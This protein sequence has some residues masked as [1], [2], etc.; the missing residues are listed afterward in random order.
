MSVVEASS[1]S[2]HLDALLG[3]ANETHC[4][5][6]TASRARRILDDYHLH[7]RALLHVAN[8]LAVP[9]NHLADTMRRHR[10]VLGVLASGRARVGA[11]LTGS[12]EID[13]RLLAFPVF[14]CLMKYV[15]RKFEKAHLK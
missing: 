13:N 3:I 12:D 9:S 11:C 15:L 10:H 14:F 6:P 8:D 1:S 4:W 2:T 7:T 5:R